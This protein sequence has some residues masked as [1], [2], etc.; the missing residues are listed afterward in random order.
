M[1]HSSGE[2]MSMTRTTAHAY[3]F[4]FAATLAFF[5]G[6]YALLMPLPRYLSAIGLADWQV[7]FV[8]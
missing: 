5:V 7:G 2:D 6:F 1:Q 4:T 8:L 3:W